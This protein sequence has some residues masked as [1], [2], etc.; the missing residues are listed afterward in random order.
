MAV[1]LLSHHLIAAAT[2][3][4]LSCRITLPTLPDTIC[5]I[6]TRFWRLMATSGPLLVVGSMLLYWEF[7]S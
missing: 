1:G 5:N 3:M 4:T 7:G 2:S 6:Q